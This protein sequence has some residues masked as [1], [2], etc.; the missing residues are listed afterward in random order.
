MLAGRRTAKRIGALAIGGSPVR[1][2]RIGSLRWHYPDQVLGQGRNPRPNLSRH[3]P[4]PFYGTNHST[5][6]CRANGFISAARGTGESWAQWGHAR[7]RRRGWS[8][9]HGGRQGARTTRKQSSLA[10]EQAFYVDRSWARNASEVLGAEGVMDNQRQRTQRSFT[11]PH[12]TPLRT[13]YA[14]CVPRAPRL[15]SPPRTAAHLANS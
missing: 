6:R 5:S 9:G 15:A 10:N 3:A 4:A 12:L 7:S 2:A 8:E 13:A 1:I 14:S 11:H